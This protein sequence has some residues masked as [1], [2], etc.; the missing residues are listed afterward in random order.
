MVVDFLNSPNAK[1]SGTSVLELAALMA[2]QNNLL[3]DIAMSLLKQNPSVLT[4]ANVQGTSPANDIID[5]KPHMVRFEVGGKSVPV[6]SI[7]AFS[8]YDKTVTFSVGN[9]GNPLD[10]LP[11]VAG[12]MMEF[13]LTVDNIYVQATALSGGSLIINGPADS[14]HGGFFVYG[15]TIPDFDRIRGFRREV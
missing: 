11:F 3:A 7:F 1:P 14:T 9:M 12:D 4:V 2:E 15:F 13:H 6:Y 8:T 10:G 5:T